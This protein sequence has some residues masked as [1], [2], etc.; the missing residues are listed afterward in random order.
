MKTNSLILRQVNNHCF[1]R[2]RAQHAEILCG[3]NEQLL[4]LRPEKTIYCN[5]VINR[6]P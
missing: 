6:F 3:I 1:K 2:D 5:K 4:K